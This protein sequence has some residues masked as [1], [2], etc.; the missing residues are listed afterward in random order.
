[1]KQIIFV[2]LVALFFMACEKNPVEEYV[3]DV[4]Q[5]HDRSS[6]VVDKSNLETMK[7]YLKSYLVMN[8]QYPDSIEALVQDMGESIDVDKYEYDPET[9][10]ISLR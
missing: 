5:A 9:G 10:E 8:G 7:K 2:C 6:Q 1:M 4:I 3:D